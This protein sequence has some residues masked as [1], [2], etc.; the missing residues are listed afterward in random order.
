[1]FNQLTYHYTASF[2]WH[3]QCLKSTRQADAQFLQ[4]LAGD[5]GFSL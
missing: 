4:T 5:A 3:A 2:H 1:M